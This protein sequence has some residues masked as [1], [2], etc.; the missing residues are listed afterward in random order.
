MPVPFAA[1]PALDDD[2][3]LAGLIEVG[4]QDV[5]LLVVDERAG[6]DRDDE[7]VAALAVHF[8]S[9]ARFAALRVPMVAAGEVEQCVLVGIG[10]E[11]DIAAAAAVPAVRAALGDV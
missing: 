8:L 1:L 10:E 4:E 11:D 6:R 2:D 3:L 9:H 5:V 7:V